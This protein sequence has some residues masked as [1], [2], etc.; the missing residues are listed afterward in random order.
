MWLRDL[1]H[2]DGEFEA[3]TSAMLQ[4][5]LLSRRRSY[6]WTPIESVSAVVGQQPGNAAEAEL[7]APTDNENIPDISLRRQRLPAYFGFFSTTT[8]DLDELPLN[9]SDMSHLCVVRTE[10]QHEG[11]FED[12]ANFLIEL[13][14]NAR[15]K[16]LSR[17]EAENLALETEH[18]QFEEELLDVCW[19]YNP[20]KLPGAS[21]IKKIQ[22]LIDKLEEIQDK[23][24]Q[25]GAAAERIKRIL[26]Y[27]RESIAPFIGHAVWLYRLLNNGLPPRSVAYTGFDYQMFKGIFQRCV[28][29]T[30]FTQGT[31]T[32][33]KRNTSPK[34]PKTKT[35]AV[36]YDLATD[37]ARE[38]L[39]QDCR[40][41]AAMVLGSLRHK[42][43]SRDRCALE[44]LIAVSVCRMEGEPIRSEEIAFL[45]NMPSG[46]DP[47]LVAAAGENPVRDWLPDTQWVA[48][49]A[50]MNLN[51]RY[52]EFEQEFTQNSTFRREL[53]GIVNSADA[54]KRAP[55]GLDMDYLSKFRFTL[56]QRLLV[57]R[58]LRPD[59]V[60][61]ATKD[62]VHEQISAPSIEATPK[63]SRG[64]Q[65]PRQTITDIG[66]LACPICYFVFMSPVL[67]C[68]TVSYSL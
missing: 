65:N 47:A 35:K 16:K 32:G 45:L 17:I 5:I 37:S 7:L 55:A 4:S 50:L 15:Q 61:T 38:T 2:L 26:A 30:E 21:M 58:V 29:S 48:L 52:A 25:S 9:A 67:L 44:L 33:A 43:W 51:S 57:F 6:I 62:F 11:E 14:Q 59:L 42:L 34:T 8:M 13:K 36:V 18:A 3:P 22:V 20:D 24:V 19:E 23:I 49:H 27:S 28:T 60:L 54:L 46:S 64:Q 41:L 31:V 68:L 63:K 39:G 10:S 56:W 66:R 53:S 12:L 1:T 40:A